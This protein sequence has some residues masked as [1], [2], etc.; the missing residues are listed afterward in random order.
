MI[1]D[2]RRSIDYLETRE[3]ID[4][5][6]LA[7]Y[8]HSGGGVVGAVALAVEP[9][10]RVGILE[11]AGLV[12]IG[13]PESDIINYL[14]RVHV[15][16]LQL[17]GEFDSGFPAETSAKPFFERLGTPAADKRHVIA[18]GG[19]FVPTPVYIDETLDWL[20]KYLGPPTN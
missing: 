12:G 3:D 11:Q 8:G 9:R 1:K 10:L 7:Y 4:A 6:A 20:D 19:H 16:V 5:E 2:L 15:P 18:P 13:P 17:N 14:P